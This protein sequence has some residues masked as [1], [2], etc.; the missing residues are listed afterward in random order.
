MRKLLLLLAALLFAGL[1]AAD[2]R[3]TVV[4]VDL[5]IERLE[6]FLRDDAGVPF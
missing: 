3:F 6:L 4:K 1:A 5:R 2:P